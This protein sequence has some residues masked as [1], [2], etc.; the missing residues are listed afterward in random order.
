MYK[1]YLEGVTK[2]HRFEELIKLFMPPEDF[3]IVLKEKDVN[4]SRCL[5]QEE[6]ILNSPSENVNGKT[7]RFT[8]KEDVN[9]LCR[10]IFSTL[11]R[12]T[13]IYPPWGIMTG[14]RPIKVLREAVEK[15]HN[16]K[17]Y[18]KNVYLVGEEKAEFSREIY[19]NQEKFFSKNKKNEIGVY[20]GIPFCPTR[21]NYCSFTSNQSNEEDVEKYLN[22]L[23][24]EMEF[25]GKKCKTSGLS[26]E[27]IYIG[28]GTPTTLNESQ[29]RRFLDKLNICFEMGKVKEVTLEAGRPDTITEEKI[30]IIKEQGINRISINPQS[31]K[32][33]TLIKIGRNH[34]RKQLE[35]AFLWSKEAKI[36]IVNA[37]IIAGLPGE[38]VDDFAETVKEVIKLKPANITVHTLALKRTSKITSENKNYNYENGESIESMLDLAYL[39]LRKAEYVP[40][41]LY[42]Q[43]NMLGLGENVGFCKIGTQNIYNH[44]IMDEKQTIIALGAGG[45]SKVYIPEENRLERVA[46]VSNYMEYINRV[47]EMKKRKLDKIFNE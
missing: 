35:Q 2:A 10:E 41:Y 13:G 7:L 28:G 47:D 6:D 3:Y 9:L 16:G 17:E 44:R 27:S 4:S 43:K 5:S 40:Y 29:L 11:V 1:F 20:I 46:N 24:S 26:V 18:L 19:E 45:I 32:D 8:L 42:R 39:L 38:T 25:V 30:K 21:C 34:N 31:I 23:L 33:E 36:E 15:G 12:E 22:S 37:D 14:I